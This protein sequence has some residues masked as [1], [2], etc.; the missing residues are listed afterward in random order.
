[1]PTT[2]PSSVRACAPPPA[3]MARPFSTSNER[4][5]GPRSASES[6]CLTVIVLSLNSE[7]RLHDRRA[8]RRFHLLSEAQGP[9]VRPDLL[10]VGEALLLRPLLARVR[11]AER[12]LAVCGPDGILLLVVDDHLVDGRV[13]PL[14]CAHNSSVCG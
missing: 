3:A 7:A 12:V 10:D 1:M 4:L 2:L 8:S 11:P 13:F 5:S 14:V 6:T 9:H